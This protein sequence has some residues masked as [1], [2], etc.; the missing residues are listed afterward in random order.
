MIGI[1]CPSEDEMEPFKRSMIIQKTSKHSSLNIY[2]GTIKNKNVILLFSGVCKVN[3]AISAQCII[4]KYP[5]E[6]ILVSGVAGSINKNIHIFDTIIATEI[7]HH[8]VDSR[9]LTEYHPWLESI[10]FKQDKELIAKVKKLEQNYKIIF[11]KIITGESFISEKYKDELSNKFSALAVDM[12]SASIAQVC[13][14]N[15]TPLL[16]IRTITDKCDENGFEN[17]EINVKRS[18]EIAGNIALNF[19]QEF[20]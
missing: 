6:M 14:A 20:G 2:E 17:F 13:S 16:T 19:I 1:I 8:D 5:I 12:E 10:W 4:D 3:A 9:I 15:K 18:S 7:A 11:G